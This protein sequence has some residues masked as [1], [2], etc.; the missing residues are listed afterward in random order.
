MA[1]WLK[2]NRANIEMSNG[3]LIFQAAVIN[4]DAATCFA[5]Q[6]AGTVTV[7]I[8]GKAY[9]IQQQHDAKAYEAAL[10]YI[11]SRTQGIKLP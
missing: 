6:N 3:F 9:N 10:K 1:N 4:L 5:V 11:E 7:F 2:I 8:E